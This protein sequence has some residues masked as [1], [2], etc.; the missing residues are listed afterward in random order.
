MLRLLRICWPLTWPVRWYWNRSERKVGKRFVTERILRPLLPA[1]PAG[2]EVERSGG[3]RVFVW[4]REDLGLVALLSGGFEQAETEWLLARVRP[5]TTAIDVGANVGMYTVPLAGTA[6]RVLA[7]E[8]A[9]D[10]VRRLGENLALNGLENVTVRQVALGERAGELLLRLG[11][12][13]MFHSTTEVAEQRGTGDELRVKACVLD[14]EWR[15]AGSPEVSALKVDVEGGEAAVLRG[16]TGLLETCRPALLLEASTA[17]R[18]AKLEEILARLGY[19][20]SQPAGFS[21]GNYAF[22][23]LAERADQHPSRDNE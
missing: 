18:L 4:Y 13:P 7:F 19:R 12:D 8:P 1:P 6:A 3:G 14:D 5:G 10:N 11:D 21:Q 23:P 2:L 17:E 9:P 16:A 15:A 22:T 20:G